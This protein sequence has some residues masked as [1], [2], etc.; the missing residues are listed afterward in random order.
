MLGV[1]MV[2]GRLVHGMFFLLLHNRF[3]LLVCAYSR[4][5]LVFVY[6]DLMSH[7]AFCAQA[8]SKA[9]VLK[10]VAKT[11]EKDEIIF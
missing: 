11:L 6:R 3:L 5:L 1:K 9:S 10:P 2:H 8:C 7:A 4:V